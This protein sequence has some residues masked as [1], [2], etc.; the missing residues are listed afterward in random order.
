M[1]Q[2]E[3]LVEEITQLIQPIVEDAGLELVDVQY[4]QE[5]AGWTLRVIIYK[6]SGVTLDDC[7]RVSRETSHILDV[8]DLIP[9]KYNLE[10]SSPGLDRP[11]KTERDFERNIG[12]KV[13]FIVKDTDNRHMDVTGTIQDVKNEEITVLTDSGQDVFHIEHIVKAKLVIEF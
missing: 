7:T 9:H 4:R 2:F 10:V 11:L 6:K 13:T 1:V 12:E 8:E 5:P 3:Q